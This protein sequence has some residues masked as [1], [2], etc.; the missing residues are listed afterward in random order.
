[1]GLSIGPPTT[2]FPLEQVEREG[3]NRWRERE[4][5]ERVP[6]IEAAAFHNLIS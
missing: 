6:K 4:A 1:M 3:E 2:W 5:K